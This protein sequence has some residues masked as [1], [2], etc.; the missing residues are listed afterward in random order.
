[1]NLVVK[2]LNKSVFI[3]KNKKVKSIMTKLG[4]PQQIKGGSILEK[5]RNLPHLTEKENS[6]INSESI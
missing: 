1:M 5:F 4:L 3:F 6:M 2:I